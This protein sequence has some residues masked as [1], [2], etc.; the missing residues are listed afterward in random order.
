M[1]QGTVLCL[2]R[3]LHKTENRPLS[4][5]EAGRIVTIDDFTNGNGGIIHRLY[6][7]ALNEG[8]RDKV[9]GS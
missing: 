2:A 4:Y 3:S 1:R 6:Y 8:H 7:N 5:W 9:R